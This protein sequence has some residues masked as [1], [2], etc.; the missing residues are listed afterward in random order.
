MSRIGRLGAPYLDVI[1]LE[2]HGT[3]GSADV[4]LARGDDS[5]LIALRH[6][7]LVHASVARSVDA[8]ATGA[9]AVYELLAWSSGSFAVVETSATIEATIFAAPNDLVLEGLRRLNDSEDIRRRLPPS[10]VVL[11]IARVPRGVIDTPLS[12]VE[13][14]M[15]SEIDGR[16]TL[17]ETLERSI[18]GVALCRQAALRLIAIGLVTL[19]TNGRG[20]RSF[21]DELREIFPFRRALRLRRSRRIGSNTS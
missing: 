18:L 1:L 16:R 20:P 12:A 19:R 9:T 7:E 4:R 13:L 5:G 15:L 8:G 14:T 10:D 6:G 2:L 21:S 3:L 11:E 17:G